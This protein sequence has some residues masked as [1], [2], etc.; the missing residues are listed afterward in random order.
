MFSTAHNTQQ[1]NGALCRSR[2]ARNA[3]LEFVPSRP[4]VL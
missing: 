3:W 4:S 1:M 2:P